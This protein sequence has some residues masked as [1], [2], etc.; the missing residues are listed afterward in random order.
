[1]GNIPL[2]W[3]DLSDYVSAN[4]RPQHRADYIMT[5]INFLVVIDYPFRA[6]FV[7][8]FFDLQVL[9]FFPVESASPLGTNMA[10]RE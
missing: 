3:S 6:V 5:T 4:P 2:N 10:Q 9:L 7:P 1:M 8:L